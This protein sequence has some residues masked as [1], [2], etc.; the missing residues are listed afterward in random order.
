VIV[1]GRAEGKLC[2]RTNGDGG[3]DGNLPKAL[4]V[5]KTHCCGR[6][7]LMLDLESLPTDPNTA[8]SSRMVCEDE[9]DLRT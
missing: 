2:G 9:K 7:S 4:C 1:S 5:D 3:P 6:L 8:N